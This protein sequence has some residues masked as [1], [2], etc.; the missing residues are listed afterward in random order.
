MPGRLAS[1]DLCSLRKE[2]FF[3]RPIIRSHGNRPAFTC[4]LESSST[5][6]YTPSTPTYGELFSIF[7]FS[8]SYL[9]DF[10]REPASQPS[11]KKRGAGYNRLAFTITSTTVLNL[12]V[13][14]RLNQKQRS[15]FTTRTKRRA[16]RFYIQT[17]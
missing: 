2:L 14:E 3:P 7:D 12:A 4:I 1:I 11:V 16:E 5:F 8:R 17:G 10:K 13:A 15:T 9:N 6:N